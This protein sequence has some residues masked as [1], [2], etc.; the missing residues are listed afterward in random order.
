MRTTLNLDDEA[1]AGAQQMAPGKT[2]TEIINEALREFARRRRLR[3]LLKFE[4]KLRWE[5]DLDRLRR[6]S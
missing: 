1:L 6:R 5:G 3:G 4:G 2:K